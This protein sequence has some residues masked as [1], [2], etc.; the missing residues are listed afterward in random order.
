MDRAGWGDGVKRVEGAPT[1]PIHGVFMLTTL[2]FGTE[3]PYCL[4]DDKSENE[5]ELEARNYSVCDGGDPR[6]DTARRNDR[7]Y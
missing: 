6:S 2:S 4:D 7:E 5:D 1:S 3:A